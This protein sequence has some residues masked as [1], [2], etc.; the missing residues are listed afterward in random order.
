M[1]AIVGITVFLAAAS[2]MDALL[3]DGAYTRV[4]MRMVWEIGLGMKLVG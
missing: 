1:R 3:Y 4:V 2:I